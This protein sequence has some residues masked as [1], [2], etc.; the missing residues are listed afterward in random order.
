MTSRSLSS[1][2]PPDPATPGQSAAAPLASA[3]RQVAPAHD[4]GARFRA[5]VAPA[6]VALAAT[7]TAKDGRGLSAA[8][9]V[10]PS[11]ARPWLSSSQ[12]EDYAEAARVAQNL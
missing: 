1:D 12:A 11:L 5:F 7:Q 10:L 4:P 9:V 6:L 3:G 2:A 8:R